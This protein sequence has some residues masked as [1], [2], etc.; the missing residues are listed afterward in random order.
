[1]HCT[2][3]ERWQPDLLDEIWAMVFDYLGLNYRKNVR[4]TCHRFY[5]IVNCPRLLKREQIVFRNL[6]ATRV[7][8]IQPTHRRDINNCP[9][10]SE[11]C[12]NFQLVATLRSL[13]TS[14]RKI[15]NLKFIDVN[16]TNEFVVRSFFQYQGMNI[17]SLIIKDGSVEPT[18]L[19]YIILQCV[20]LQ[21]LALHGKHRIESLYYMFDDF[22]VLRNDGIIR[23]CVSS[24]T[25]Y[26]ILSARDFN[27]QYPKTQDI[28][29]LAVFPNIKD[30]KLECRLTE[31]D[32]SIEFLSLIHI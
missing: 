8:I 11:I 31:L 22:N 4:L 29:P 17:R 28:S 26:L 7:E 3:A 21:S 18:L 32:G 14:R 12:T 6:H 1:M 9:T 23:H 30:L 20:N 10:P 24:F 27:F 13:V 16:L 19:S 25:L 2:D 15:W 5:D